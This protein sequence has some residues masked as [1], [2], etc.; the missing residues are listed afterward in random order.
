MQGDCAEGYQSVRSLLESHLASGKDHN[1]Q[2]CVYVE[3]KKVVD[4]WGTSVGDTNYGP[5]DLQVKK[6]PKLLNKS[7]D[8]TRTIFLIRDDIET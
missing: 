1:A 5:D 6:N 3:G 2:L 7:R 4:L 8:T